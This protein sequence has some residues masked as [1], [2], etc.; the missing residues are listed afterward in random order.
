MCCSRALAWC[1]AT[2]AAC[3]SVI[4]ATCFLC[5]ACAAD[6]SCVQKLASAW[7]A[8]S[9]SALD[10]PSSAVWKDCAESS[11]S[12]CSAC[13][14]A[15]FSSASPCTSRSFSACQSFTKSSCSLW[16]LWAALN[17]LLAADRAL[18]CSTAASRAAARAE[19]SFSP[20]ACVNSSSLALWTSDARARSS[21]TWASKSA[22]PLTC[23]ALS[24]ATSVSCLFTAA[25]SARAWSAFI[26]SR[27][28]SKSSGAPK[29]HEDS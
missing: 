23:W 20:W 14:L 7:D 16:C 8:A 28:S 25:S 22:S 12:L 18:R 1:S 27:F 21:P 13:A 3:S 4:E 9:A 15:S 17:S 24:A 29:S 6:S 26:S 10:L 19:A 11:C 2:K 5:F